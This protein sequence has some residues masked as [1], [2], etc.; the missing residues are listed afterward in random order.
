MEMAFGEI[1]R[2]DD[3]GVGKFNNP[4]DYPNRSWNVPPFKNHE[5]RKN[6]LHGI[7]AAVKWSK[8]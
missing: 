3:G 4:F 1:D 8:S 2:C 6:D 5:G 7:E